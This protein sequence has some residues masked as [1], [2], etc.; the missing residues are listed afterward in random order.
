MFRGHTYAGIR[1]QKSEEAEHLVHTLKGIA[2]NIAAQGAHLAAG[3]LEM[4]IKKKNE[5]DYDRLLA[6]LDL[7]LQP[8]WESARVLE[9]A[10]GATPTP[11]DLNVDQE[12]LAPVLTELARL[13]QENNPDAERR[14]KSLKTILGDSV[15]NAE[16]KVLEQAI[17]NYDFDLARAHLQKMADALEVYLD[18]S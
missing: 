14:L 2:G 3:K 18:W 6:D 5:P 13:V 4:G 17:N 11:L 7:S 8:V 10:K 12:N 1:H 16:I 15:L 9:Q